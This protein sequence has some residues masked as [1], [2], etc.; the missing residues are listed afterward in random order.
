MPPTGPLGIHKALI[1][2]SRSEQDVRLIITNFDNRF[3]ETEQFGRWLRQP[4][5]QVAWKRGPRRLGRGDEPVSASDG[6]AGGAVP[7]SRA[8]DPVACSSRGSEPRPGSA[9]GFF[10]CAKASPRDRETGLAPAEDGSRGNRHPTVKPIA[11]MQ[12]L[13]RLACPEGGTVLD[14]FCGS[15]TTGIAARAKGMSFVGIERD[16]EY[17]ARERIGASVC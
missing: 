11:L 14:P 12:W 3:V 17:A 16:P 8:S 2:L 4:G 9:A 15:G 7:P 13:F 6:A 10:Y 1:A 5:R